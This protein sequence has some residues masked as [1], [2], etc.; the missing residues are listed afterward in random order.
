MFFKKRVFEILFDIF[1]MIAFL[2]FVGGIVLFVRFFV[3]N[4]YTVVG[5]SMYPTFEENDF[6]VVDKITPRFGE[7][8]RGDV[9]VFVPPEKTIPYIKRVVAFPGETVKIKDGGVSICKTEKDIE[10]C[11]PLEQSYL[12]EWVKTEARCW[13]SEFKVNSWLFVMWD[14]RWFST[15]S[16]CCFGLDCYPGS[17][18]EVP[19]DH[20]IWKVYIRFFPKFSLF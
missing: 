5:A 1:D 19:D 4:P 20:I 18:Y 6:I 14:N 10:S 8:K 16:R 7:I 13:V 3:A 2:V 9:I 15:D 12:P 17:S 11:S